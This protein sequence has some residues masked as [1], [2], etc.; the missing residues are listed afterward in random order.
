MNKTELRKIQKEKRS[1]LK[2]DYLSDL[3]IDNFFALPEFKSANNIFSYISFGEEVRTNKILN[4]NNKKKFVPKISDK[5][6]IM[7]EYDHKNLIKNKYG[8]LEP[9]S[10]IEKTPQKNDIIIVPALACDFS[11]NRLGYGCGFYDRFLKNTNSVKIVLLPQYLMIAE[12]PVEEHDIKVDIIVT[13]TS[14]YRKDL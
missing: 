12:I 14:V 10:N 8:I 5:N 9:L 1:N 2:I 7:V 4:L 3:I 13:E 6:M 11:F